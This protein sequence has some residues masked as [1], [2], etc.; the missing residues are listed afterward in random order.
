[1]DRGYPAF[2]LF[3]LI[4]KQGAHFCARMKAGSWNIVKDFVASGLEEQT[5][6]LQPNYIAQQE[7]E[8]RKLSTK[9]MLIR[10]IRVEL[11]DGEIEVLATSLL[12]H[13][14]YPV[15]IFKELYHLRWPVEEQYKVFKARLELENFS[16]TSVL[17]V[18]QDFHAKVFAAN[19]TAI[20]ARPAQEVV[21]Q[22]SLEKKYRWQINMTN[23][24]S[25]MKDTIVL[26]FHRSNILSLLQSLWQIMIKTIEPIRP[27]RSYPRIWRVKPKKFPICYKPTR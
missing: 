7:G 8:K 11:E 4:L 12:D 25:K 20:L 18:Y 22:D 10:L 19:L 13:Q 14:T 5:V 17:A 3:A 6:L 24:L 2:W 23:A 26:F 27:G 16:G 15:S 9:R 1:L 21:A